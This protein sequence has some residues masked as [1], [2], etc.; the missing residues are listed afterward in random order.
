MSQINAGTPWC[1]AQDEQL[2][3]LASAGKSVAQVADTMGRTQHGIIAR[4]DRLSYRVTSTE[5]YTLLAA[6]IARARHTGIAPGLPLLLEVHTEQLH[7]V[8]H[9]LEAAGFKVKCRP[10]LASRYVVS[11]PEK[12]GES[13]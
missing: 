9:A 10:N 1:A 13:V 3:E 2:L 4:A 12:Q 6:F 11:D 8:L 5:Q 7:L